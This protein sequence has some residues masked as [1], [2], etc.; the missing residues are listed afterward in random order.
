MERNGFEGVPE[1]V[2]IFVR[3]DALLMGNKSMYVEN[4]LCANP[5]VSSFDRLQFNYRPTLHMLDD[6]FCERG[7]WS[8]LTGF[9]PVH[10]FYNMLPSKKPG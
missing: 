3:L 4:Y 8:R 7:N 6:R 1:A 9:I 5:D 10:I 2:R